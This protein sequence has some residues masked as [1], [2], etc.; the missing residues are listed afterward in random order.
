MPKFTIPEERQEGTAAPMTQPAGPACSVSIPLPTS[1]LEKLSVGDKFVLKLH[2]KVS[3]ITM[4]DGERPWDRSSLQFEVEEAELPGSRN[5]VEEMV[6]D[7]ERM[8]ED[9]RYAS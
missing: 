1:A 9:S 3:G 5:S 7:L 4:S 2:G 8:E 6:S